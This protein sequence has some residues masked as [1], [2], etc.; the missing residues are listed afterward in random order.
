MLIRNLESSEK[1]PSLSSK[2]SQRKNLLEKCDRFHRYHETLMSSLRIQNPFMRVVDPPSSPTVIHKGRT[3]IMLGSNNY[4]GLSTH[5]EVKRAARR[6]IEVYGTGSCSSRLLAGTTSLH[7]QLEKELAE[8]KRT[9]EAL[10]FSTGYMTMMGTVS[11]LVD[12]NDVIFSD[13]LNHASII[14]GIRLS[15]AHVMIY[16]H[17]DMGSLEEGLASVPPEVNKLIV[18]DGVFSMKGDI[19][20]IPEIKRLADEYGGVVMVDDAHGTG[21]LGENGRGV[22]E[23]FHME[24][25]IDLVCCTFSKVFGSVGGA[26]GARKEI[27]DFLRFNARPY[28]FTASLPPSVVMTVLASLQIL[29]DSPD[30]INQLRR[31]VRFLRKNLSRLHFRLEPTETPIIPVLIGDDKKTLRMAVELDKEGVFVNPVVPPAVS[32]ESS[33]I[34]ISVMATL[35][36]EELE[37]A[38]EKFRSV[39][40]RLG[41]I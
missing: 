40:R 18:T 33:L 26:V 17:N 19:A 20:N 2:N 39:G 22:L 29:K 28:L 25:Q 15:K 14:D 1:W 36:Q 11:G 13:Q 3:L 41:L 9:E 34:R 16:R 4:L 27:V 5:P 10:L 38:I 32:A 6:A 12:E 35:T 7:I 8:F 23:H 21:V 30:L 24:G 31:N 37:I